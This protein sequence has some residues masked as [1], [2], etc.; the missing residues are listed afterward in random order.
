MN[1]GKATNLREFV[2]VEGQSAGEM[3]KI[4]AMGT[5]W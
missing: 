1:D 3:V 2:M 4:V 5:G